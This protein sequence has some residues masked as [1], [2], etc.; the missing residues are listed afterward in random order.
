MRKMIYIIAFALILTGCGQTTDDSTNS[1]DDVALAAIEVDLQAP[2]TAELG[3]QVVF[4]ATVTHDGEAVEDADEVA[5]EIWQ[6]GK[7]ESSD[8]LESENEG[9]GVYSVSIILDQETVYHIQSHVTARGMHT[10]PQAETIVGNP[11]SDTPEEEDNEESA[12]GHHHHDD[13][14]TVNLD[15]D[16]QLTKDTEQK[17]TVQIN[18]GDK[19]LSDAYVSLEI[20]LEGETDAT[21]LDLEEKEVGVYSGLTTFEEKGKYT[22]SIH[23]RNDQIHDHHDVPVTVN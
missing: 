21:W 10:M 13:E 2:E 20:K 15:T 6:E 4:K 9:L 8:T 12:D 23:V 3:E 22:V 19:P 14:I 11:D 7:K 17:L 1:Q 18:N 5:F 16:G